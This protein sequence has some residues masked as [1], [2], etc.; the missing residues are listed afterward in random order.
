MVKYNVCTTIVNYLRAFYQ[1]LCTISQIP[2]MVH[3]Y[4]ISILFSVHEIL[5][6]FRAFFQD[7]IDTFRSSLDGCITDM[8]PQHETFLEGT[9]DTFQMVKE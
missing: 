8:L 9:F 4:S 6:K 5:N 1:K 2:C 3:K 7:E